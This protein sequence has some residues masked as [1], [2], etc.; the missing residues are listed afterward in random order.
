MNVLLINYNRLLL[1]QKLTDWCTEHNYRPI[2]IDN[3]SDY[4]PLLE[5]YENCP[6]EVI[7]L[8]TN[9][10]S[11]VIWR[12][13]I[14]NLLKIQSDYIVTDPDLDLSGVPDDL[15]QVLQ[16]GLLRYPN[17]GKCG[18]SLKIDDLPDTKLSREVM[19]LEKRYWTN[20]LDDLYFDAPV[21][22]TFA[23]YRFGVSHER[24]DLFNSIRTKPPYTARHVPWYYTDINTLSEDE[25]YYFQ[26]S[27]DDST[28]WTRQM[29]TLKP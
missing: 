12:A 4:P 15:L 17:I 9:Y 19:E 6:H 2:I 3:N 21:D 7:R 25:Q 5:Y 14:L 16:Q 24:A 26:S 10:G 1:P 11:E 20:S 28:Y 22:T 23:L 13:G 27:R 29:K 8:K 18:L